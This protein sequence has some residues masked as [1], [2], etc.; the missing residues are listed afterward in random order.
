[1]RG[2][3][4]CAMAAPRRSG[5]SSG[6]SRPTPASASCDTRTQGRRTRC[7]SPRPTGFGRRCGSAPLGRPSVAVDGVLIR[8]GGL[9]TVI[10][11]N[12]PYLGMHALPG[13]HVELGETMEA[14]MLREFHEETGLRVE[15][16]RIV[17]VY[18]DP[19]RDPRGPLV[20]VAYSLRATG[21]TL[22]ARA[23]AAGGGL[24]EPNPHPARAV[25]HATIVAGYLAR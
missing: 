3:F 15:V 23:D 11:G 17:G 12:P 21:G 4:S 8:E 25:D 22:R 16:E 6:S 9:V 5:A 18:S 10:R 13:G 1:M 7:G 24:V 19:R 2:R 20:S 14:A